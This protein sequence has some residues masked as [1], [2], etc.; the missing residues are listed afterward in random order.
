MDIVGF[1]IFVNWNEPLNLCEG[2]FDCFAIRNNSIPLFGKYPSKKLRE[3]MILNKVKRVNIILDNDALS[4]AVNNYKI[5]TREIPG[6]KVSVIKL[7]GKD[8]SELGFEKTHELIRNA[9]LF[10]DEDL[11][12]YEMSL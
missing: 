2:V 6:I 5:L 10:G 4:D 12:E 9:R 8:P 3:K 7:N 1:E 11:M